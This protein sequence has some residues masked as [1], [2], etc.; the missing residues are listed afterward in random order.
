MEQQTAV[1]WIIQWGKE[2][3]VALQSDYYAAIEQAKQ[4]EKQQILKAWKESEF[5]RCYSNGELMESA[6]LYYN[7]TYKK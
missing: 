1:D 6:E 7:E 3:P 2:N 5:G 4:M